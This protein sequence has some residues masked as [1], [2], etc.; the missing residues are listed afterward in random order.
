M[1]FPISY[2]TKEQLKSLSQ[3]LKHFSLMNDEYVDES[4]QKI[5]SENLLLNIALVLSKIILGLEIPNRDK[6]SLQHIINE[7]NI[8]ENTNLSFDNLLQK[9]F[10]REIMGEITLP[11]VVQR[12]IWS[13]ERDKENSKTIEIPQEIRHEIGCL[14]LYYQKFIKNIEPT[15]SRENLDLIIMNNPVELLTVSF[16][17]QKNIIRYNSLEDNYDWE[18]GEYVKHLANEITATLW[19]LL[20]QNSSL[21]TAFKKF[22]RLI[23]T[24]DIWNNNLPSL[25]EAKVKEKVCLEA[26]SFLNSENDLIITPNEFKK[27]W[28]DSELY[29]HIDILSPVPGITFDTSSIYN[30]IESFKIHKETLHDAFGYQSARSFCYPILSFIADT[31]NKHLN[32]YRNVLQIFKDT[33]RP[34][35]AW[36]LYNH[37]L[38]QKPEVIPHMLTDFELIPLAFQLIDK[39]QIADVL[40]QTP[41][42]T[43]NAQP[44]NEL[45]NQLW[46][47]MLDVVL[48]LIAS[49]TNHNV[50]KAEIIAKIL[51]NIANKVFFSNGSNLDIDYHKSLRGRYDKALTELTNKRSKKGS[52]YPG[53]PISPRII[54]LLL[55][56]IMSYLKGKLVIQTPR[57]NEY[58][59]LQ[60]GI[61][62]LCI[63][64]LRRSNINPDETEITKQE[65]DKV[66]VSATKLVKELQNY[67]IKFYT[68]TNIETIDY[69]N[70]S[71]TLKK[72][73][74]GVNNFGF[75]II[76]WGYLYLHFEKSNL[77]EDTG[78]S[79]I[80]SL[81]FSETESVYDDQN[82]EQLE[83]IRLFLKSILLGFASINHKRDQYELEGL[84]VKSTLEK[85]EY[86]MDDIA[87]KHTVDDL[88]NGRIDI[89]SERYSI[90]GHDIYHKSV[91]FLLWNCI[92]YLSVDKQ[93]TFVD[94]FFKNS[95]DIGKML[96]SINILNSNAIAN[97]I[98]E[99]IKSISL[100]TFIGSK[101]M[102]E[103]QD[104]L[105]EAINSENHWDLTQPLLEKIQTHFEKVTYPDNDNKLRLLYEVNM[106]LAFKEKNWQKLQSIEQPKSSY[107]KT[108]EINL[109]KKT[110]F[111]A[112]FKLYNDKKY[113]EAVTM[114]RALLSKNSR[115]FRYAYQIYRGETLDAIGNKINV[116]K[117]KKA[118]HEW[119]EFLSTLSSEER[120]QQ[121]EILESIGMSSLHV[122]AATNDFTK[123]DQL[124]NQLSDR[125][126]F[127][128][129][130]VSTVYNFY[131]NRGLHELA[132][133]YIKDSEVYF[134]KNLGSI[135][136][137]VQEIL[138]NSES[139]KLLETLKISLEKVRNL[140]S[141]KIPRIAPDVI[142]DQKQLN[143]FILSEIIQVLRVLDEKREAIKQ[144]THENRYNDY[145]QALLRVRFPFWGWSILDQGRFRTSTSGTD[146]GNADLVIQD[147]AS[148]SIA[149]IECFII[150]DK[151]YTQT[152]I[153]KCPRYIA[154]I[155]KYYVLI[156]YLGSNNDFT[157]KWDTYKADVLSID[158]P[159]NFLIDKN[160]GFQEDIIQKFEDANNFKIAKTIHDSNK[161]VFHVM[162]NLGN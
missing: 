34:F 134:K 130:I 135:P 75:E 46:F 148:K 85:L 133:S 150:R 44:G 72:I 22:Y 20:N 131:I 90:F 33:S 64:I 70:S 6:T 82:K 79:V 116:Q 58:I 129:E 144:I 98:S 92:N 114:F 138:I 142:N 102:T 105:V 14:Q 16:L 109:E 49:D 95:L 23:L 29:R 73:K 11:T 118:Y 88:G 28:L 4:I 15:I 17:E 141:T 161:E 35:I 62:D 106:L 101:Y 128:E 1:Q 50:E 160:I 43:R 38:P 36:T 18:G 26:V 103:L 158:Y 127:N 149:L 25:L 87:L 48:T 59:H 60:S 2:T 107:H 122:F 7:Y 52:V 13:I 67:V 63:E 10:V 55:P 53:D 30:L 99:K 132:Y 41:G 77:L 57:R 86:W 32:P 78:T 108:K 37:T 137:K 115:N 155:D 117:L 113:K 81:V 91:A 139:K 66:D 68:A 97:I 31:D 126:K 125:Y 89:F 159:S 71:N 146:A 156:Y 9:C 110:Y 56:E 157:E 153:L 8:K 74:R 123:F 124:L 54:F 3:R 152:H 61:F 104:T 69:F 24:I 76:D 121:S 162:I 19:A 119:G 65:T 136:R 154:S 5:K 143:L 80:S 47:E 39:M 147:G 40:I 42:D 51:Y 96:T 120:K 84:P 27:S 21:E 112:L 45:R 83:K 12:Y 151:D 93:K 140:P 111:I 145:V 94:K 100:D